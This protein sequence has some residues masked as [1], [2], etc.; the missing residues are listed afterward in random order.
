MGNFHSP[1]KPGLLFITSASHLAVIPNLH[2][3]AAK[4][5]WNKSLQRNYDYALEIKM[6][7][8]HSIWEE[9]SSFSNSWLFWVTRTPAENTSPTVNPCFS[10]SAFLGLLVLYTARISFIPK[11]FAKIMPF[12]ETRCHLLHY[13][14]NLNSLTFWTQR[15]RAETITVEYS[16]NSW[17]WKHSDQIY[18]TKSDFSFVSIK[19]HREYLILLPQTLYKCKHGR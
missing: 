2:V 1:T 10:L 12:P 13:P 17:T 9:K 11:Y 16:T 6:T 4:A 18:F 14:G 15:P 19:E 5:A 8:V 3:V 7:N